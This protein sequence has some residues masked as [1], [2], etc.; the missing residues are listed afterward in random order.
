MNKIPVLVILL[1]IISCSPDRRAANDEDL[2]QYV[3]PF[4]IKARNL[5]P[6]N[7]YVSSV[8]LNG[9]PVTCYQISYRDIMQGGELVFEMTDAAEE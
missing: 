5:T 4:I 7:K 8:E 6:D 9:K 1:V 2:T 3:N